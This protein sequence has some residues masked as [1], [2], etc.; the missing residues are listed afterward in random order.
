MDRKVVAMI[1]A[2]AGSKGLPGKNTRSLCGKPLISYTIEAALNCPAVSAVYVNSDDAECLRIGAGLGARTY[3]RP[4]ALGGD[5]V[6]M[7]AT[8][9]DF[10]RHLKASGESFDAVIVLYP[11]YPLRDAADLGEI[12]RVFWSHGGDRPLLGAKRS[13]TH[14]FLFYTIDAE[15]HPR[16]FL[17]ID[18]NRYYR[19][20]DYPAC[21]ELTHFACVV[22]F[23]QVEGLNAQM[24]NERTAAMLID[25][26][27]A[28][29]IDSID[30]FELA[31]LLL[32][33]PAGAPA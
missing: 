21:Y 22:P 29:D 19:R 28:L 7:Q 20:Q 24:Q 4:P 17:E 1:P 23:D 33:R 30:D 31:A 8:T 14:P 13:R 16:P 6:T 2:R 10:A 15:S 26:G 18:P 27:K 12:L 5:T 3:R 25:P 32:A 9:V 11:T